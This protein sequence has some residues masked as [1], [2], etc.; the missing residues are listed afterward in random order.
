MNNIS[1]HNHT[2]QQNS[3]EDFILSN[4]IVLMLW[5]E[6]KKRDLRYKFKHQIEL[7]KF[8]VDFYCPELKLVVEVEKEDHEDWKQKEMWLVTQGY[9]IIRFSH[10]EVVNEQEKAVDKIF[11]VCLHLSS[12]I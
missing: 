8:M 4:E 1:Y 2:L 12:L 3:V 7:G 5:Q 9:T 11:H 10:S 6:L